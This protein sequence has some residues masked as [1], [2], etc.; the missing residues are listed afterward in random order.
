MVGNGRFAVRARDPHAFNISRRVLVELGGQKAAP[1]RQFSDS[2][3]RQCGIQGSFRLLIYHQAHGTRLN[4]LNNMPLALLAILRT[5]DKDVTWTDIT[6]HF[7][8][9]GRFTYI[10]QLLQN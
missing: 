8:E 3:H 10:A 9:T 2:N 7:T 4:R 6:G 1:G 5:G